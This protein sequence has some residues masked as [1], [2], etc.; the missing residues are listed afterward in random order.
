M[1]NIKKNKLRRP[2]GSPIA[3]CLVFRFS[4][5]SKFSTDLQPVNYAINLLHITGILDSL[6]GHSDLQF[7]IRNELNI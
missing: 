6:L 4:F 7:N 1:R 3:Q 5:T 2:E